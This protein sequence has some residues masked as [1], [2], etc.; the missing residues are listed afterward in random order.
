MKYNIHWLIFGRASRGWTL[1]IEVRF[2][3]RRQCTW[4]TKKFNNTDYELKP[5]HSVLLTFLKFWW[6][7]RR[8][9]GVR[10]AESGEFELA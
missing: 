7:V 5:S 9:I 3:T 1:E 2:P 6:V 4:E 10:Q 8:E